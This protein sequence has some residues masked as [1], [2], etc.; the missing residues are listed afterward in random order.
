MNIENLHRGRP[1]TSIEDEDY[2]EAMEEKPHKQSQGLH[3][4]RPRYKS[5]DRFQTLKRLFYF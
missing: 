4:H 1:P 3:H 2:K 5:N